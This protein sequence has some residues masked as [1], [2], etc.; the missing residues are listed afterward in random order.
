VTIDRTEN[1]N[2]KAKALLPKLRIAGMTNAVVQV[3]DSDG[4]IVYALRVAGQEFQPHVFAEGTYTVKV[5][6]PET[7]RWK[8]LEGLTASAKNDEMVEVEI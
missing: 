5:G 3:I 7:D 4:E 2:R 1:Y 6:E 8:V